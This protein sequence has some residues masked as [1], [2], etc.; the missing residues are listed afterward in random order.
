MATVRS[1]NE[2]LFKYIFHFRT[3][4]DSSLH[5][6]MMPSV[7]AYYHAQHNNNDGNNI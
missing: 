7:I 2:I 1:K 6:S 3:H 4:S 5:Q